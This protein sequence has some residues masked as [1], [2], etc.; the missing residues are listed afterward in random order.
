MDVW[1]TLRDSIRRNGRR[2]RA[3]YF[4][5]VLGLLIAGQL[6][7]TAWPY[8]NSLSS[9][10]K[11]AE[12]TES[13]MVETVKQYIGGQLRSVAGDLEYLA[14]HYTTVDTYVPQAGRRKALLENEYLSLMRN[15]MTYDQIRIIGNNGMETLRT[16]F[17]N[18]RPVILPPERYQSKAMRCYFIE[19]MKLA[20]DEMY[21]SPFDLNIENEVIEQPAKPTIRF[22]KPVFNA[23]GVKDGVLVINYLGSDIIS[24]A[25]R[26]KISHQFMAGDGGSVLMMLNAGGYFIIGGKAAEEWG[27]MYPDRKHWRFQNLYPEAWDIVSRNDSAGFYNDCGLFTLTTLDLPQELRSRKIVAGE[28]YWKIVSFLPDS[29]LNSITSGTRNRYLTLNIFFIMLALV[30]A[31]TVTILNSIRKNAERQLLV[32]ASTDSL[33]MLLNRRAF[34]DRFEYERVR[35][36]R[37]NEPISVIMAD[38]DHFKKVNDTLGHEAGDY[39][40]R[41]ISD[42]FKR[43]LREQDSICRWGGEEFVVLLPMTDLASSLETAEKL[44][45][46]VETYRFAYKEVPIMVTMSFGVSMYEQGRSVDECIQRADG[47]LYESKASGRNRVSCDRNGGVK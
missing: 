9:R 13:H 26:I 12:A 8:Y 43:N 29:V 4:F 40:L 3:R 41:A 27:F 44:R 33:T 28:S 39:V 14:Q 31:F 34:L 46:M 20:R 30:I 15:R 45:K 25:R 7:V 1:N 35:S 38:I 21:I 24:P 11:L 22:V 6:L 42:I 2:E 19:G 37:Y 5:T 36:A 18:G 17:N 10:K 32:M 47:F 23:R 16:S